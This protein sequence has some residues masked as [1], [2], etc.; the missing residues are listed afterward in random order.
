VPRFKVST[1]YSGT[2]WYLGTWITQS[3]NA[4]LFCV[5]AQVPLLVYQVWTWAFVPEPDQIRAEIKML[6]GGSM[7]KS[8]VTLILGICVYVFLFMVFMQRFLVIFSLDQITLS[9]LF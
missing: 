9:I 2:K 3:L 6:S 5:G 1:L 4:K 7:D 8:F